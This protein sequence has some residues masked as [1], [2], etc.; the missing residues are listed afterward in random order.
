MFLFERIDELRQLAPEKW[1]ELPREVEENLSGERPLR[2]YQRAALRNFA[3]YFGNGALRRKPAQ[4]LFHMATGSGKTLV[5]AALILYLFRKGYRNFLFF[6]NLDN[7]VKKTEAN[8][9]DAASGKYLFAPEVRMGGEAVRIRRVENFQGAD[10]GAVNL[11]FKTVQGLHHDMWFHKEGAP[12]FEDFAET[13][14]VLLADE[15]HHLAADTRRAGRGADPATA[16]WEETVERIFRAR[17]DNALLE[18]TATCNVRDEAIRAKYEDKIVFDY[19]LAKFREER[20]SKEVAAV[21]ADLSREERALLALLFSQWRL[22]VFADHRLDV[23]PVV[24]FKSKTIAESKAFG[25]A[26]GRL[27]GGLRGEN[28]APLLARRE[29]EGVGAMADYFAGKGLAPED[30]ARELRDAFGPEHCISANDDRETE[31][32]QLLLNSLESP[33]NPYRAVFEVK[34]LDEGWDVL[35]LFDI[36]RLYETRDAGRGKVGKDTTA[37][38][39]LIGRGARYWPFATE[40]GQERGR[41]KFDGDAGNP[42]RICETLLYHCQYNPRYFTELQT[43]LR[44]SGIV[45]QRRTAV[46]YKLKASFRESEFYRQG[47][48]FANRRIP[49]PPENAAGLPA[50]WRGREVGVRFEPRRAAVG[51]VI[52]D[53]GTVEASGRTWTHGFALGDAAGEGWYAILHKAAREFPALRFDRLR[54]RWPALRSMREFLTGK[55]WCG[56]IRVRV[57]SG[58]EERGAEET[59]AGCREA[60]R[61]VAE[62]A[63]KLR[64]SWAGSRDFADRPVREVF[65]DKTRLL[66][67]VKDEGEGRSQNDPGLSEE[68]RLDLADKDWYAYN[69]NFGTT[70]EKAFVRFFGSS[71]FL[72]EAGL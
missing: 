8:F 14:V 64:E 49:K 3:T 67:D 59:L 60:L 30:L 53:G 71:A 46:E 23:K 56:G 22:K 29:I 68:L 18:F 9:L 21:R 2:E 54:E 6:V 32:R 57:E 15:A 47:V 26:F 50:S 24:L 66:A 5:M 7:I 39:Q 41:R 20:W 45:A 44:E 72:V 25:G 1:E 63:A 31:E 40:E 61:G 43:A 34:K 10:P 19:P 58:R 36:V 17:P 33:D 55:N 62:Y 70:E 12:T 51:T 4:V 27:V 37:E 35:N 48:V 42:L 16:S 52:G 28:L 69:D 11:C 65:T 38:A 13:P